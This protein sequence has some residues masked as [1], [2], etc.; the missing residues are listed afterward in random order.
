MLKYEID[1]T[2]L[3]RYNNYKDYK[4]NKE[5][6]FIQFNITNWDWFVNK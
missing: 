4:V 3:Q 2:S 1:K 5:I 6:I